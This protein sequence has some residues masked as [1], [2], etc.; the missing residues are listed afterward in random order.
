MDSSRTLLH[1]FSG[2]VGSGEILLVVGKPG[3]GCTTFLKTLANMREEY[4]DTTGEITYSGR[5]A[6]VAKTLHFA[7]RGIWGAKASKATIDTAVNTL[8]QCY[9]LNHVLKTKD[10]N[11][12]IRGVSGG[13]RRRV[14]LA[15]AMATCPD[16][17]C[18]DN[19][20]NGLDSSTALEFVQ[21]MRE[22]TNQ[23]GCA[24]AMSVYQG[25]N[26]KVPLFDKVLVI[27][28]GRQIFY[29]KASEAKEYFEGLGFV[30]P[31]RTTITD[32]LNS[33]T[34]EPELRHVRDGC[35]YRVP[36]TPVQFEEAF[37]NSGHYKAILDGIASVKSQEQPASPK[38][39]VYALPL[40]RQVIACSLRQFRVLITDTSAWMI[41]AIY[42]IVQS[43]V[44]G[45]SL[46]NTVLVPALQSMS[47][48][49]GIFAQ[50]PLVIRQKRYRF[51]RPIDYG[52]GLVLTD[53]VWKIVAIAYNIPQYFL[54]GF[55]R[56]TDKFLT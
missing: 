26:S 23:H 36:T 44:L 29:G 43:F 7:I 39:Q 6:N 28:A 52:L 50:R 54:T 22:F 12:A 8:A 3:T 10:G 55:Q 18:F 53:A 41:E 24:T 51:Y 34:A 30:C 40:Y 14:S 25:S 11:E 35:Q 48:F 32:F 47:E 33:M 20:T 9:G 15:E 16:V 1:G 2:V 46:I 19:P 56:S 21:M 49:N 13:E 42:I 4:K 37:R 17:L 27:S 38:R 31:E 45:S 5:P